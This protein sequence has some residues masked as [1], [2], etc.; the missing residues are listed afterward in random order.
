MRPVLERIPK[1]EFRSFTVSEA[2]PNGSTSP[3]ASRKRLTF[4]RTARLLRHSD[5]DRVYQ[6]GRRHFAAHLTVFYLHR[7]QAGSMRVGFTVGK[8]LGGG[9]ERNRMKRRLR[10]AVRL[11][12]P[13]TELPMDVVINPKKS[14]RKI[15]FSALCQQIA[16]AFKIIQKFAEKQA[17]NAK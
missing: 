13:A 6:Q 17:S 14:M 9:V 8:V 4:P 5:F 1:A 2:A 10:E 7:R 12:W 11:H 15:E 3:F 16:Q